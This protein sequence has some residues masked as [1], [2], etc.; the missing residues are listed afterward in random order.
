MSDVREEVQHKAKAAWLTSS[1]KNSIIA[2][3]GSGKSKIALDI[4]KE[5]NPSSILLLTNAITLR[6]TNWKAEFEKFGMINYWSRVCSTTYQAAYKQTLN[7]PGEEVIWEWGLIILDEIDFACTA[8][9][10]KCF[11]IQGKYVLGLTGFITDDKRNFL[12]SYFPICYEITTAEM[13]E[14]NLLNKSE[15]IFIEFPLSKVRDV[16]KKLKTGG[17]FFSSEN[18]EYEYWDKKYQQSLIIKSKTE[19]EYRKKFEPFEDKAEWKKVDWNFKFTAVRRKK[20]LTSL[21]SSVVVTKNILAKIHSIPNNKVIIFSTTTNQCDKLPNPF[22]NKKVT[23][24]LEMLNSG[25]V[26]TLSVVKKITRGVNLVGVNYLIRESFD[27]SEEMFQQSHGRLLRLKPDQI[28]KY[29]IL[30]PVFETMQ[31]DVEGKFKKTILPTQAY[32]WTKKMMRSFEMEEKRIIRLDS[33]YKLKDGVL[34]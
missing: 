9:Y 11:N 33:D 32:H 13:Q 14:D 15:F 4:I 19:L 22:H 16:P 12:E 30:I 20:I 10:S 34:L 3:V 25:A 21:Q 1:R 8:E 7:G 27:G 23:A 28:A 29:I 31:R 6:D 24:T 18:S 26:N 5:L 17:Q 2:S